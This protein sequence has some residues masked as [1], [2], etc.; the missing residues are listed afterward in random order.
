MLLM[1]GET[2][3]IYCYSVV[4]VNAVKELCDFCR[5]FMSI[6]YCNIGIVMCKAPAFI[7]SSVL[8]NCYVLYI[9]VRNG[10]CSECFFCS[11]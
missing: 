9:G 6:K 10:W 11:W 1:M 5:F 8:G 7:I 3:F 4:F 2:V